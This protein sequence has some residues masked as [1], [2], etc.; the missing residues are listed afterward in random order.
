M[1]PRSHLDSGLQLVGVT[2]SLGSRTSQRTGGVIDR[3]IPQ[4]G[5]K[6]DR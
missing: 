5:L 2:K 6:N 4:S 3:Q 1:G